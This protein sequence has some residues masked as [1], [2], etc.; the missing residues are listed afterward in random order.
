MKQVLTACAAIA[1]A[2]CLLGFA[3]G[4]GHDGHGAGKKFADSFHGQIPDM[5]VW[6]EAG[7]PGLAHEFL[8]VFVGTWDTEMKMQMAPDAPPV[9]TSGRSVVRSI[10]DGRFIQEDYTS[11]FMGQPFQGMSITGYDNNKK[12]FVATWIDNFS[13]GVY[14]MYGSINPEGNMMTMVGNMD[15]PMT[16]EVGKAV[17]STHEIID[18]DTHRMRSYDVLYGEKKLQFEITYRRAEGSNRGE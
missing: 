8:K 15:E 13:T 1:A 4:H 9:V 14:T 10:M 18:E 5:N 2:G 6:M 3:D 12:Q 16:G 17:L 11:D 7:Q